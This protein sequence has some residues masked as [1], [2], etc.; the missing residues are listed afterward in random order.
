MDPAL[1]QELIM[2]NFYLV[3]SEAVV[4][5]EDMT[6]FGGKTLKDAEPHFPKQRGKG[7]A[8]STCRQQTQP[9]PR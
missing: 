4:T 3:C 5:K 8:V 9:S 6:L 7:F 2:A 1:V